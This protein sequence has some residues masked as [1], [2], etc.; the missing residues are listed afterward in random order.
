MFVPRICYSLELRI[1]LRSRNAVAM[2]IRLYTY[3]ITTKIQNA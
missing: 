2:S 1:T 3:Y